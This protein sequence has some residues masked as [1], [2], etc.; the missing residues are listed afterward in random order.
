M[1]N[2]LVPNFPEADRPA[3]Q[4]AAETW[5]L[6]YWDW[7]RTNKVPKLAKYPTTLVPTFDGGF[8]RIDNP[9]YQFKMPNLKTWDS[10]GVT[11]FKDPW[12]QDEEKAPTLYVR[13][14]G[15][16]NDPFLTCSSTAVASTPAVAR[17]KKTSI[18]TA[19]PGV[20]ASSTTPRWRTT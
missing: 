20:M 10:E 9:L 8:E 13:S 15:C 4:E 5:R 6:P 18:L 3:W 14:C 11:N 1:I 12:V 17:M 2:E 16:V 19:M 7:A